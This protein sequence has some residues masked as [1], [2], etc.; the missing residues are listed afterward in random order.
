MV[1]Y[2]PSTFS[3]KD[4]KMNVLEAVYFDFDGVL[5]DSNAIKNEAYRIL[6]APYGHEIV[7]QVLDYHQH[8]GGISRVEKIRLA[9]A[10]F[11]GQPLSEQQ[12]R[13]K[14]NEYSLLV[15]DRVIHTPW[16]GG[17]KELLE[18]LYRRCHVSVISGTP[19][20]ELRSIIEQ[21]SM[22]HYFDEILG[23]PV[24]KPEHIHFLKQKYGHSPERSVFFGDASTDYHAAMEHGITFIGIQGDYAFPAGVTVFDDFGPVPAHLETIF[25]L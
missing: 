17:A 23:S 18:S 11:I 19:Q 8:H 6:F 14:A 15:M 16:I 5:V 7:E 13:E 9:F 24:H 3:Q 10:D 12:L 2:H 1:H 21:R 25:A 22:S 20:D 4:H